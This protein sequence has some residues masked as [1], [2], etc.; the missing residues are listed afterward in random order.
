[1]SGST[2]STIID[3][4]KS[5]DASFLPYTDGKYADPPLIFSDWSTLQKEGFR[6]TRL[7]L[8]TQSGT[9]IDAPAHFLK[10]GVS[11][12]TLSPEHLIGNYFLLNLPREPSWTDIAEYL[13]TYRN[14]NIL[15]LRTPEN[16]SVQI[17]GRILQEIISLPPV[18]VVLSGEIVVKDAERFAFHRFI[19][20]EAK[21]LVEDLD[22]KAA[23]RITGRGEIFVFPLKLIGV[24]GSPCRVMVRTGEMTKPNI[25]RVL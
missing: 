23:Q 4:T 19:A 8:G 22:Q 7:S 1:M 24:S 21:F 9:H 12:E 17:I 20:G 18:L 15:F 6:V 13:K 11:L 3:L 25:K 14:E 16:Q 2:R 5:L 10:D